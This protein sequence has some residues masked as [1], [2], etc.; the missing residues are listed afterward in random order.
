MMVWALRQPS[1]SINPNGM[2]CRLQFNKTK[3]ERA[4]KR[5]F[6]IEDN[7]AT[8]K[9]FTRQSIEVAPHSTATCFFCGMPPVGE[10]L[11]NASTFQVDVR[12][13]CQIAEY[14][15]SCVIKCWGHDRTRCQISYPM[16]GLFVQ[17][18]TQG[19]NI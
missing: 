5:K 14:C 7:T 3:L 8:S 13:C 15:S 18:S 19:G 9:K 12:V 4:E 17:Q 1:G 10:T 2:T 6:R 11:R 16:P